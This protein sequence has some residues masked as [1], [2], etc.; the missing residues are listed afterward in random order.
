MKHT[1]KWIQMVCICSL[2]F[3]V[4]TGCSTGGGGTAS[5]A[6]GGV[7]PAGKVSLRFAWWG[8]EG[9]H[10]AILEAISLYMSKHPNV[11]IEAEYG[12]F[13]GY[14]QKLVTQFAGGTAPDL[15]PLSFDWIDEIA[16]KGDLVMDL[17]TQKDNL[18]LSAFN[19]D[20]LNKYV[21]FNNKMVGLP[22]GINGMVTA[23]NK[24]FFKKFNIPED[25]KWD[26][27]NLH[28]FG[29]KVHQQ[30]ANAYLLSMLDV[31]G[32]LQPYVKQKTGKQ[33]INTDKTLG[34]DQ[35][36][37]AEALTYYKKLLDDGV[38]QPV[39]ESSLYPEITQN[40]TW[41]K[42]NIG[43]AFGL[44][45]TIT[46][47]KS[48]IPQI[49]VSMYPVPQNA[50]D[51]GVLVNPSN[52]LAINKSSK[53]PEEAAKFAGWLL[54]DPEA[55][56]ILRDTYSIPAVEKN[57]QALVEKQL[58]DP[59]VAKAVKIALEKPG[60]PLNGISSN[61][62]LIKLVEDYMQQVAFGRTT[63]DAAAQEIIKRLNDKLKA[64]K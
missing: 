34:F 3:V 44:S 37:L 11:T 59:T 41:Q 21:V 51:S 13:D 23:Y 36:T 64:I 16:V 12:G 38:L 40:I 30:D 15:T 52:P 46:K 48:F 39:A 47:L 60:E 25:T 50:K 61:Q 17:N 62:E 35:A 24:E 26:W 22:M 42:G 4:F 33:W 55:A 31:R 57:S 54:T 29:K 9:R 28:E 1:M 49:D 27:D 2:L 58:V 20:F 45:S 56:L 10:K 43:I 53:F 5:Q 6:D 14:Y 18:N 32:F 8:S 19:S 63:P 7:K